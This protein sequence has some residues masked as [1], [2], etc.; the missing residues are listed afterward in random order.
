[1]VLLIVAL[2]VNTNPSVTVKLV[3]V[4]TDIFPSGGHEK[5]W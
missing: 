3:S 5:V 2:S 4:A 1:M